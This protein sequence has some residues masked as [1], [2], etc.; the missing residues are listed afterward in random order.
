MLMSVS[1]DVHTWIFIPLFIFFARIMDVSI[2][3]MRLILMNRGYKNIAPLLGFV[4]IFIWV[5]A[6]SKIMAN[7]DNWVNYIFYAGGFATGNYVGMYIE[8]KLAIGKVGVRIITKK[9]AEHLIESIAASGF[10]IT[11]TE[12]HGST[13]EVHIIFCTCKRKKLK[14]LLNLIHNYNPKAFYTIEDVRY[15]SNEYEILHPT[16]QHRKVFR[17][18]KGK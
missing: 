1:F 10:G 16:T 18:R 6:I 11:Y 14:V 5:I 8:E 9:G 2:G 15:A 17:T 13:G 7:L 12:A 3:T 4:E